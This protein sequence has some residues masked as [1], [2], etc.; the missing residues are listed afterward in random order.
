MK[1]VCHNSS[2]AIYDDGENWIWKSENNGDQ[3]IPKKDQP[4]LPLSA[5]IKYEM[6]EDDKTILDKLRKQA[7]RPA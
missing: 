3:I 1:K 2:S 4:L 7:L 6:T 5:V